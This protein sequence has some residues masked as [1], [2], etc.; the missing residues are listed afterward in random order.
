MLKSPAYEA[1]F[2]AT[3]LHPGA[4]KEPYGDI[5]KY[6]PHQGSLKDVSGAM[7][8]TAHRGQFS[9]YRTMFTSSWPSPQKLSLTSYDSFYCSQ[10]LTSGLSCQAPLIAGFQLSQPEDGRGSRTEDGGEQDIYFRCLSLSWSHRLRW[11]CLSPRPFRPRAPVDS[12]LCQVSH[13][14]HI[15]MSFLHSVQL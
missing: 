8:I 9:F 7:S 12:P 15:P 4:I 3:S 5:R 6:T 14:F 2:L 1:I 11:A 13:C 10:N